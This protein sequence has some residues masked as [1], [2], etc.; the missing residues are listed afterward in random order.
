MKKLLILAVSL[1]ILSGNS[2]AAMQKTRVIHGHEYNYHYLSS[3]VYNAMTQ[4]I[5]ARYKTYKDRAH[6]LASPDDNIKEFS[7]VIP[8]SA[9]PI[10]NLQNVITLVQTATMRE[11]LD[12]ESNNT[13]FWS[14]ATV[15][16]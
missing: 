16:E 13:N 10:E 5:Y 2:F 7:V 3:A 12:E 14:D 9:V 8:F 6:F 4:T 1:L 11:I 15:V